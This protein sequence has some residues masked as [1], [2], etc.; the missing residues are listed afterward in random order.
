MVESM[1]RRWQGNPGVQRGRVFAEE[2]FMTLKREVVQR[3]NDLVAGKKTDE[4]IIADLKAE[5]IPEGRILAEIKMH[6]GI[7]E[8]AGGNTN[9]A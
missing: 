6:R 9:R 2:I 5:K 4:Q 7:E 1:T 3:I 8:S